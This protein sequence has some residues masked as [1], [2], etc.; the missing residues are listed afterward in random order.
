[1]PP[2]TYVTLKDLGTTVISGQQANL[3]RLNIKKCFVKKVFETFREDWVIL[4]CILHQTTDSF[5]S[6]FQT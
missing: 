5:F 4:I 1:M 6:I 3:A 2:D